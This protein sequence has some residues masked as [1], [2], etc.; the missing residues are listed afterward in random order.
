MKNRITALLLCLALLSALASGCAGEPDLQAQ[1]LTKTVSAREIDTAGALSEAS[2]QSVTDFCVELFQESC[3]TGSNALISPVSVLYA[4]AMAANGA[5]GDTLVQMEAAFG[6]SIQNLDRYLAAFQAA[7]PR[8]SGVSIAN[9][10]W[11]RDREDLTVE[12]SFLQ[13]NADYFD[14]DIYLAPF[15]GTTAADINRWVEARTDGMIPRLVEELPEST[16]LCLINA[17][18]FE[19][20]WEEIYKK[21][22][23]RPG[24]F[25]RED[26]TERTVDMMYSEEA[27]FLEDEDTLGFLKYYKGRDYAFVAL[28]PEEGTPL[29]EY[30]ASLTGEKLRLLLGNIQA[31]IVSAALPKFQMEDT[32]SLAEPLAAMGITDAFDPGLAD[33]S[34]LGSCGSVP[35]YIS[36]VLHKTFLS[37]DEQKTKAA[38]A[39]LVAMDAGA[40]CFVGREIILDRPFL[41]LLIHCETG[42]PLFMGAVMD[43]GQ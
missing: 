25:T 16:V 32:L 1:D 19:Q 6:L 28:L 11:L 29:A 42:L 38:A 9:S 26:G 21:D 10:L 24:I 36:E 13:T 4:M 40:E 3:L 20:K 23:V 33:F 17:L 12:E 30:A 31:G 35:L 2:A 18:G 43:I 15:D 14:P 5:S 34:A 22:Q 27:C 7:V 8:N 39:T 37:V 41:C